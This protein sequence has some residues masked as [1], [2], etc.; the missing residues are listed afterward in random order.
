M[1]GFLVQAGQQLNPDELVYLTYDGAP[2]H[3]NA[4]NPAA[5]TELTMLPAYGL[6]LNIMERAVN[7][8]K[9]AIKAEMSRPTF[10]QQLYDW[11]EARR[12]EIPLGHYRQQ[13]LF[14]GVLQGEEIRTE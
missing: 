13:I 5:N 4:V 2:A 7:A 6:F 1:N 9:A 11:G 8:L 12:Q 14:S 3:R 10:Q